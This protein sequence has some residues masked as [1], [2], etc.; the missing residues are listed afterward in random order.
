RCAESRLGTRFLNTPLQPGTAVT[1]QSCDPTN[2][3]QRWQLTKADGQITLV[4]AVTRMVALFDATGG[5]VQQVPDGYRAAPLTLT[6]AL[7]VTAAVDRQTVVPGSTATLTV[8]VGNTTTEPATDLTVTPAVPAGWTIAPGNQTTGTIAAGGTWTAAFTA[9]PPAEAPAG[10][11][12]LGAVAT[13]TQGGTNHR[14]ETTAGVRLSCADNATSP[15]AVTYVDSEETAGENGRATNTIDGDPAT[16]W[17]TEWSAREPRPPHEIQFD[18]GATKSVCAV[19][20]LPRQG[21]TNGRFADYEIYLSTDG[22]NWG[23]PVSKGKFANT[24]EAKWVPIAATSARYLRVVQ[25]TEA[26]GNPW[27]TAAEI[28]I[29]AK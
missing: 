7:R 22:T 19:T 13:F 6:P 1:A 18:L 10:A 11:A 14:L 27:A 26:N 29:D 21:T 3:L 20:Y 17:H 28:T 12:A 23:Q 2:R 16:F 9:T 5:L 15:A 4:N 24:P 8:T 25:L